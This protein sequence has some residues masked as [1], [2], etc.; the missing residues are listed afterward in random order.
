MTRRNG[1]DPIVVLVQGNKDATQVAPPAGLQSSQLDP[2]E[3]TLACHH[4]HGVGILA[5]HG[6]IQADAACDRLTGKQPERH[7]SL[8]K[9]THQRQAIVIHR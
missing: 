3:A 6:S 2:A 5:G 8:S 1:C 4:N 7:W 9:P